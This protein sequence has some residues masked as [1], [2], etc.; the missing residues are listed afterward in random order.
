MS[1]LDE[2]IEYYNNYKKNLIQF[3]IHSCSYASQ[4]KDNRQGKVDC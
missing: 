4:K 1:E 2:N 3:V